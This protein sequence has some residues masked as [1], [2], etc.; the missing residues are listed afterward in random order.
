VLSSRLP[1]KQTIADQAFAHTL[2]EGY[3]HLADVVGVRET[4]EFLSE[5]SQSR[6]RFC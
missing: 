2:T 6:Y 5:R 1:R 3:E 4:A